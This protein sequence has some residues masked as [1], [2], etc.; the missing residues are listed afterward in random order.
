MLEN[1][2]YLLGFIALLKDFF[3]VVKFTVVRVSQGYS[4][5]CTLR[6]GYMLSLKLFFLQS[7]PSDMKVDLNP[8]PTSHGQNQPIYECRVTTASRNRVN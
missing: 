8:I 4:V 6:H 1:T 2:N 3:A 7:D 5:N